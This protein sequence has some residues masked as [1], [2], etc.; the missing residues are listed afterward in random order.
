[1]PTFPMRNLSSREIKD[2]PRLGLI[3]SPEAAIFFHPT[4]PEWVHEILFL[5]PTWETVDEANINNC[6]P[7]ASSQNF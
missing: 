6:L 7:C 2:L 4:G 5:H 3:F 1:M